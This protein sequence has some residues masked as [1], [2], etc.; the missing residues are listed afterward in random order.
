[1][2]HVLLLVTFLKR[3]GLQNW[4]LALTTWEIPATFFLWQNPL[5]NKDH[6]IF[7]GTEISF[8]ITHM[9][10]RAHTQAQI[11]PIHNFSV[12]WDKVIT[13]LSGPIAKHTESIVIKYLESQVGKPF[14]QRPS[15]Q[16]KDSPGPLACLWKSENALVNWT[17]C[18]LCP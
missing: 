14:D 7:S 16:C 17:A 11:K 15:I 4:S 12:C 9:H 10:A 13:E 5:K 8:C 6:L 2:R 1:M 18:S 3:V